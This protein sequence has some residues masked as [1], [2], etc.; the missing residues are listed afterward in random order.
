MDTLLEGLKTFLGDTT[1]L[2]V[3]L[4]VILGF[5]I[6]R[7]SSLIKTISLW[8]RKYFNHLVRLRTKKTAAK[9]E[10]TPSKNTNDQ[11]SKKVPSKSALYLK[12]IELNNVRCFSNLK[13]NFDQGKN[14][15]SSI[16]ILG[17][18]SLGKSTLLKAIALTFCNESDSI[19]LI[20]SMSGRLLTS[21][22][23]RGFIRA[24]LVDSDSGEVYTVEKTIVQTTDGEESIK[25][26]F[27]P[28]PKK[29]FICAYGTQRSRAASTSYSKYS[30]GLAVQSLFDDSSVLQNPE[31]VLLRCPKELRT[32]IQ[33]KLLDVLL[34]DSSKDRIIDDNEGISFEGPWGKIPFSALSDGYR[35]TV[36]WILDMFS[37]IIL[38]ERRLASTD[39]AGIVLIDEIEQHLHP[40]WQRFIIQRISRQFPRMQLVA[41]THTPLVVSGGSDLEQHKIIRLVNNGSAI[42]HESIDPKLL[43]GQR[44]DEVLTS[45]FELATS[46][47]PGSS[48]KIQRY[49]EL[50]SKKNLDKKQREEYEELKDRLD[51]II[52]FGEN[53]LE[54]NVETAVAE[55]LRGM[56][57]STS[58]EM[59]FEVKKQLR[60]LFNDKK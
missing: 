32:L 55:T 34:L 16:S 43:Q 8:F 5:I 24:K 30:P 33:N 56:L 9:R 31:I 39:S 18:N 45:I 2:A 36:Q 41:T 59:D 21:G 54:K 20:K 60:E 11:F 15:A 48:F 42:V 6:S 26:L 22:K 19:A 29:I 49:F 40:K 38:H 50:G 3:V 44:A 27:A 37:W 57:K 53:S 23:K 12:E 13:M 10:G 47:S 14:L 17:D 7:S 46:R 28:P 35:S 58:K 51:P 25:Q 4:G 1:N 52:S